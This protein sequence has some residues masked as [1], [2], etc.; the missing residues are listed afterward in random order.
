MSPGS[1]RSDQMEIK[2]RSGFLFQINQITICNVHL[3]ITLIISPPQLQVITTALNA[4]QETSEH[5]SAASSA[6]AAEL[7]AQTAMV[8]AAKARLQ[9]LEDQLHHTRVDFEAAR[10]HNLRAAAAALLARNNAEAAAAHAAE[11]TGKKADE[12]HGSGED[13]QEKHES[14]QIHQVQAVRADRD[15]SGRL[16]YST[17]TLEPVEDEVHETYDSFPY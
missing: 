16:M 1:C 8:G 13:E 10:H 12:D 15:R 7:A 6:A 2:W 11:V 17:V 14:M 4:A 9:A 3:L 5:T